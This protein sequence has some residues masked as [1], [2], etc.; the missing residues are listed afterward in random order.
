MSGPGPGAAGLG[1]RPS[2]A[3]ELGTRRGQPPPSASVW[4]VHWAAPALKVTFTGTPGY[5]PDFARGVRGR[6]VTADTRAQDRGDT[7]T[8]TRFGFRVRRRRRRIGIGGPTPLR[9]PAWGAFGAGDAD[10]CVPAS[11]W[12]SLSW[13]FLCDRAAAQ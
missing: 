11:F 3:G 12:S 5:G 2:R 6:A 13:T 9:A 10:T 1:S 7:C 4:A 8:H